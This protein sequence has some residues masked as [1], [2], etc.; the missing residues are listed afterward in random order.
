MDDVRRTLID[1]LAYK[2]G[3]SRAELLAIAATAPKR[4]FVWKV[5]KKSGGKRTLCHPARELK[6]VQYLYLR[7]VL[8][9][10]PVHKAATAY[11]R[12]RSIKLNALAHV[13]SRVIVK[14]DLSEFFNSLRPDDFRKYAL[15]HFPQWTT[16][17]LE[18]SL[19]I[20]FWGQRSSEPACLAIG[21]PT[22]PVLSNAIMF[23]IDEKL[24]SYAD[25]TRLVYTRYAD[26]ITFSSEA[27]IDMHATLNVVQGALREAAFSRL[28]INT[29]KTAIISKKYQR[30]VTGLVIT[31]EKQ[32]SI[33]RYKKRLLRS[34]CF[35]FAKNDPNVNASHLSGWL[36]FANDVEPKFVCSL[37]KKYGSDLVDALLRRK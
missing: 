35:R 34:M 18:F 7:D 8:S 31:P 3:L 13:R 20:L 9:E 12:G 11:V 32:V 17:E 16:E 26:D 15:T 30:R 37:R 33:G 36:A 19:K 22:S 4:Y 23:E 10:L 27:K 25:Q 24:Q 5:A 6:A 1:E 28:Q 14:I 29:R 21:A 2:L